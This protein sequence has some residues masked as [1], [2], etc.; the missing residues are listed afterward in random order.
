MNTENVFNINH[1]GSE[2]TNNPET[3]SMDWKKKLKKKTNKETGK[4]VWTRVA[5]KLSQ[6]NLRIGSNF[7]DINIF[8]PVL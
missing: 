6:L 4:Y 3:S 2:Q 8:L 5:L 1:F 7:Y